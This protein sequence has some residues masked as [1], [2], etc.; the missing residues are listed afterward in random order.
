MKSCQLAWEAAILSF[1]PLRGFPNLSLLSIL[2]PSLVFIQWNFS[3]PS[4]VLQTD[5]SNICLPT[6]AQWRKMQQSINFKAIKQLRLGYAIVGILCFITHFHTSIAMNSGIGLLRT[7]PVDL[8]QLCF[9]LLR[10]ETRC[11]HTRTLSV[12]MLDEVEQRILRK[13]KAS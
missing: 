9:I 13:P 5:L 6:G 2:L 8:S 3:D 7:Q 10:K 4:P 1:Q 11:S 12:S